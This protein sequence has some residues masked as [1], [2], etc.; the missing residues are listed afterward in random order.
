[1]GASISQ[2][3]RANFDQVLT[4]YHLLHESGPQR[5]STCC[6][7]ASP[8]ECAATQSLTVAH[9]PFLVYV[10][11]QL[12]LGCSCTLCRHTSSCLCT[13][14]P[15]WCCIVC[16]GL[17]DE[18]SQ[19]CS[20]T[21]LEGDE[22][23]YMCHNILSHP[24]TWC[25]QPRAQPLHGPF[26]WGNVPPHFESSQRC[27]PLAVLMFGTAQLKIASQRCHHTHG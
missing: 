9:G 3:C 27:Q 26:L 22:P 13:G 7:R 14:N 19:H 6:V 2:K 17:S 23:L 15:S 10:P 11:P 24:C 8:C 5:S 21:Q 12:E 18:L 20:H 16:G 4:K 1:M 25:D